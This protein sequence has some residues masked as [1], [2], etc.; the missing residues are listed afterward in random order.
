MDIRNLIVFLIILL[1]SSTIVFGHGSLID[2]M[3]ADW[4]WWLPIPLGILLLIV[5]IFP[6]KKKWRIGIAIAGVIS[7]I[8]AWILTDFY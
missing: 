2:D 1:C 5:A 7:L 6:M 4:A 8:V 3:M